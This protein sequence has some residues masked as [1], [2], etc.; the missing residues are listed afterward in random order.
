MYVR[1]LHVTLLAPAFLAVAEHFWQRIYPLLSPQS[2]FVGAYLVNQIDPASCLLMTCWQ[3]SDQAQVLET[4]TDLQWALQQMAV[5]FATQPT[6][7]SF[8][9]DTPIGP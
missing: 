7:Y 2:G 6:E 4:D 3:D 8:W 9:I 5:Y 1:I